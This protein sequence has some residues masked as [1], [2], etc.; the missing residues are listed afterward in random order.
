MIAIKKLLF[1]FKLVAELQKSELQ[2]VLFKFPTATLTQF[3]T[4]PLL[5]AMVFPLF[6]SYVYKINKINNKNDNIDNNCNLLKLFYRT[7]V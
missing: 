4:Q 2:Q 5:M 3:G 1:V 6:T 7:R